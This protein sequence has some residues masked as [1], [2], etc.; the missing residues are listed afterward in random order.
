MWY[1]YE[2]LFIGIIA[3]IAITLLIDTFWVNR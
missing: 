3:E 2:I 1:W